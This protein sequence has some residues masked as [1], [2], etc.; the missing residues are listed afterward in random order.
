V[1]DSF[2]DSLRICIEFCEKSSISWGN[3]S[4]FSEENVK[5]SGK[6]LSE[7]FALTPRNY[8]LLSVKFSAGIVWEI[9]GVLMKFGFGL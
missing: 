5:N 3:S 4:N 8:Q 1:G 9:F 6:N 2:G 7:I